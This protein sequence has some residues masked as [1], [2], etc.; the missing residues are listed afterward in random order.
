M[1]R[2]GEIMRG[3]NIWKK[4]ISVTM[5]CIV[6]FVTVYSLVLPAITLDRN[7][8][9]QDDGIGQEAFENFGQ[10]DYD[11]D[12]TGA[13]DSET[14]GFEEGLSQSA[15][16]PVTREWPDAQ[17]KE[18]LKKAV[19]EAAASG[20][21]KEEIKEID[22][23][24]TASYYEEAELPADVTFQAA[25][26]DK[27]A[28]EYEE[29]YKRALDAVRKEVGEEAQISYA[30]FFDIAFLDGGYEVE[31]EDSVSIVIEYDDEKELKAEESED[32]SIV[33]FDWED[34]ENPVFMENVEITETDGHVESIC[35][36]SGTFSVYGV[37]KTS[38]GEM[39]EETA[40]EGE[41]NSFSHS[42]M[43]GES[44]MLS[45]LLE[46]AC[47]DHEELQIGNVIDVAAGDTVSESKASGNE[48]FLRISYDVETGDYEITASPEQGSIEGKEGAVTVL[49][50]DESAAVFEIDVAG[51][52]EVDAG[53]AK[54]STADG[55]YLPDS[56]E[57]SVEELAAE[58]ISPSAESVADTGGNETVSRVFDIS[59]NLTPE[60]QAAYEGGFLVNLTLPEEVTGRDFRL[61]HIHDGI[62]EELDIVKTGS[63]PDENGLQTVS[64]IQ[65]V[66]ESFS[67]FILQYTVDF[68]YEVNGKTFEF[69]I[70]G[71]GFASFY[72]IVEVLGI[73]EQGTQSGS[74]EENEKI[75]GVN[76][77]ENSEIKAENGENTDG[78]TVY[79]VGE[80]TG[81]ENTDTYSDAISLNSV[82]V[83]DETRAFVA[84]VASVEFSSPELVWV[85][86][87]DETSTV[88]RL[89]EANGLEVQYSADLTEEQIAEIN[90]S[91][92]EGGDW[93]LISM[94][95]FDTEE[96]LTV[97]MKNGDQFAVKVTDAQKIPDS[98]KGTIDPNKSYLICYQVGDTYY[99]L[100]NDGNVDSAHHPDFEGDTDAAHNFEHLNSTY[101]WSFTYIFK[102]QDVEHHLDKNYYL[103]RPIDNKAKTL[104]LNNETSTANPLVQQGN[105]NTAL[106]QT[107]GGFILEGYHNIGTDD[108][109][110]YIHLS[111]DG[112]NF[113]GVDGEGVYISL[114]KTARKAQFRG[115]ASAAAIFW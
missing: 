57:G 66:T 104:A 39:A 26:I 76:A 115:Q 100:K 5:A 96:S 87:V 46:T 24:V 68:H 91:T 4:R 105:N 6:V 28:K 25:E 34:P 71:G 72:K 73:G 3:W 106:I 67:E 58:D 101:A 38:V 10:D 86:K 59:L 33:H 47:P 32:I 8:A 55:I 111:F 63:S 75:E 15:Q 64:G 41:Q 50:G 56:A 53:L 49:Y 113:V 11:P 80:E 107:E 37:V 42:L 13:D 79:N 62:T 102:E 81:V 69:S 2:I 7:T 35:F 30:R 40:E 31:P 14:D 48:D 65:F 27:D 85:G 16:W 78:E 17:M 92:V 88:G 93:A 103:I 97:T 90:S 84:D 114:W 70:P 20:D 109:H 83:S 52:A 29:Y 74:G 110:R 61:Y 12:D 54:I 77:H 43:G 45:E 82:E 108:N 99:L 36:E 95:P 51:V 22:Y 44:I 9:D 1:K 112:S 94:L 98:E 23:T 21:Q 89:K 60:E 19:E 18:A